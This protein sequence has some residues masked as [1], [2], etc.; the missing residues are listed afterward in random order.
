MTYYFIPVLI[1]SCLITGFSI[2]NLFQPYTSKKEKSFFLF[3]IAITIALYI[4]LLLTS[5]NVSH[6]IVRSILFFLIVGAELKIEKDFRVYSDKKLFHIISR[7]LQRKESFYAVIVQIDNF[8]NHEITYD[9]TIT[10]KLIDKVGN[11]LSKVRGFKPLHATN[12]E[13]TFI[14][15]VNNKENE[16]SLTAKIEKLFPYTETIEGKEISANVVTTATKDLSGA[17]TINEIL[18]LIEEFS[19][20][21]KKCCTVS[22]TL[23]TIRQKHKVEIAMDKALKEHNLSL[24]L[25]PLYSTK[26]NSYTMAEALVRIEDPEL[27]LITP[28]QFIP[29]AEANGKI[30]E[31]SFQMLEATCSFLNQN[32]LPH[33]FERVSVN[34]SVMDF[35]EPDF[36]QK[37]LATMKKYN[38]SPNRFTLEITESASCFVPKLKEIMIELK[39][40][41]IKF[42]VDDFGTGY[43][44]LD[45]VL[46]LPFDIVKL[47]RSLL[48]SCEEREDFK[49]VVSHLIT[50]FNKVGFSTVV[51]GVETEEQANMI[52]E[53]MATYQQGFL[54]SKP[55]PVQHFTRLLKEQKNPKTNFAVGLA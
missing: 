42:A 4:F 31:I 8:K 54:Y 37:I 41:G 36:A 13:D 38:V 40:E 33:D 9:K 2:Y 24:Y 10:S 48:I 23:E 29:L 52:Q 34:L 44:N 51:E 28:N 30:K 5:D 55:I 35:N 43:A 21:T 18:E 11:R 1:S 49:M 50:M 45:T 15:F 27:G 39:K 26:T 16:K 32:S 20:D 3:L 6:N 25:Q 12:K 14:F 7:F 46:R 47:D 53:M 17:Q 19:L 22:E